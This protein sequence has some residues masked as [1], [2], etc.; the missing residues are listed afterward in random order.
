MFQER[1]TDWLEQCGVPTVAPESTG[2]IG[3]Q[4][5]RLSNSTMVKNQIEY[6]ET[7]WANRAPERK[8]WKQNSNQAKRMGHKLVP[9]EPEAA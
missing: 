8:V 3:F 7:L 9:I 6:D 5:S 2:C 1:L 4:C